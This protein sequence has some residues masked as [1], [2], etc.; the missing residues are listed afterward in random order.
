VGGGSRDPVP[1]QAVRGVGPAL[2][3]RLREAGIAD[4]AEL[5]RAAPE[6]LR[7]LLGARAEGLR[8]AA[9]EALRAA[10]GAPDGGG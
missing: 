1:L 9:A 4:A 2:A 10:G 8:E 6:R 7:E 5:A 3:G